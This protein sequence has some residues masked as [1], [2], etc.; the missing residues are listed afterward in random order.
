[1]SSSNNQFFF[2]RST[3]VSVEITINV[4]INAVFIHPYPLTVITLDRQH[5]LKLNGQTFF[6]HY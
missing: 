3:A 1:M 4:K 5:S 2:F 6:T